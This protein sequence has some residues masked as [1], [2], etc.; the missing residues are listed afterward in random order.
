MANEIKAVGLD[1]GANYSAVIQRLDGQYWTGTGNTF[2][3]AA[4]IDWADAG[5]N[6]TA[7][8]TLSRNYAADFPAASRERPFAA[9]GSKPS[10]VTETVNSGAWSGPLLLMTS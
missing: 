3:A 9:V 1:A 7:D 8:A 10:T 4:A 2:A 5:V 6:L